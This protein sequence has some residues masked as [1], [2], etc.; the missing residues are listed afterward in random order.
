MRERRVDVQIDDGRPNQQ[1]V[2]AGGF[3]YRVPAA[4]EYLQEDFAE[5]L[6]QI[7]LDLLDVL[8]GDAE[9]TGRAAALVALPVLFERNLG[10]QQL[11]LAVA[12]QVGAWLRIDD[13]QLRIVHAV[14][15]T[16]GDFGQFLLL[17]QRG[18]GKKQDQRGRDQ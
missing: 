17:G 1:H 10:I 3:D 16:L 11:D 13:G 12:G 2:V 4:V 5:F 7:V 9:R 6:G 8:G 18:A 14:Q 15:P